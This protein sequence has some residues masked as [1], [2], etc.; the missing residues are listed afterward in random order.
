M[1]QGGM[2]SIVDKSSV[3]RFSAL[4][5]PGNMGKLRLENR[6]IMAAMGNSL[7]ADDGYVTEAMTDYYR[8]RARGDVGLIRAIR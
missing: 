4:F 8:A 5:Q 2:K 1:V 7:A 6:L 3:K